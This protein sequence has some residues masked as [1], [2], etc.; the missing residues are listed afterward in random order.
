MSFNNYCCF[1]RCV[2][3]FWWQLIWKVT[4]LF[5][6]LMFSRFQSCY[7][8]VLCKHRQT[9]T[10]RLTIYPIN[11]LNYMQNASF[12]RKTY[13]NPLH[14]KYTKTVTKLK[15]TAYLHIAKF[16][17]RNTSHFRDNQKPFNIIKL[18]HCIQKLHN[19]VLQ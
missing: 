1:S 6:F 16:H 15:V 13:C 18:S 10:P 17:Y 2:Q 12:F 3:N 4:I 11:H 9:E 8:V 7:T 19:Y 14:L 5:V